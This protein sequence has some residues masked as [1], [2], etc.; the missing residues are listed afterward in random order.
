MLLLEL[1]PETM[2]QIFAYVGSSYF[3]SNLALLTVCKQWSKF[4]HSACFQDFHVTQKTLRRFLSTPDVKSS[5]SLVK[6]SAETLDLDLE[7]FENWET[8]SAVPARFAGF[9][10]KDLLRLATIIKESRKLR[11]LRIQATLELH[12]QISLLDRRDYLFP[13]TLHAM[14]SAG[15]LTSLELDLCGTRIGPYQSQDPDE[16]F[17]VCTSIASFLTTLRRLRLRMCHVCAECYKASEKYLNNTSP[18]NL[19]VA[20]AERCIP[21]S[22]GFLQLKADIEE[23]AQALATQM[24]APKMVRVLTH[25]YPHLTLRACDVLTGKEISLSEG[26]E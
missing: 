21:E 6:D 1:P 22:G 14:L 12:P 2:I 4:A 24:A 23:Q 25:K 16:G 13:F 26:A 9:L 11:T 15:N 17:H 7:G 19:S 3:R 5:L 18:L 20:H 10:N 8:I